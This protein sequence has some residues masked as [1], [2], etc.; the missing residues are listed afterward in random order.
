MAP[1]GLLGTATAQLSDLGDDCTSTRAGHGDDEA[2]T[3]LGLGQS[4]HQIHKRD[5]ETGDCEACRDNPHR[6]ICGTLRKPIYPSVQRQ[7][8]RELPKFVVFPCKK[9]Q[10]SSADASCD[11]EASKFGRHGAGSSWAGGGK[12]GPRFL[13]EDPGASVP[14]QGQV[15][16]L[17]HFPR[18]D[19]YV[20]EP[21]FDE[22]RASWRKKK[23]PSRDGSAS[24][25]L[26]E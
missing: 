25:I 12:L 17:N 15:L 23:K 5:T 19:G 11:A 21:D 6:A 24:L 7:Q 9:L 1:V 2:H 26:R 18:F 16:D 3:C 14:E 8:Q 10:V 13:L 20:P 4:A 22:N